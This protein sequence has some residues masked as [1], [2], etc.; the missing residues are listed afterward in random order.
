MTEQPKSD[1][2]AYFPGL[3]KA[4]IMMLG[5]LAVCL[6]LL[7]LLQFNGCSQNPTD[8]HPPVRSSFYY[9]LV[10]HTKQMGP[11]V[12]QATGDK[13]NKNP[14]PLT[15]WLIKTESLVH[16][17][18]KDSASSEDCQSAAKQTETDLHKL[19]SQTE[20]QKA[21]GT[22]FTAWIKINDLLLKCK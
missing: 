3:Q 6:G 15:V 2:K 7:W 18:G 16:A 8:K 10:F 13:G 12:Y 4:P 21:Y 14:K 20:G 22:G 19:D 5:G 11:A 1:K 9:Q 17:L